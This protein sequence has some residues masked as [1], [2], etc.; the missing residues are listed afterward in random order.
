MEELFN[1]HDVEEVIL[2]E[3]YKLLMRSHGKNNLKDFYKEIDLW[4]LDASTKLDDTEKPFSFI[5]EAQIEESS[6]IVDISL[7]CS[8]RT[9][10]HWGYKKLYPKYFNVV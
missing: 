7:G 2:E 10:G 3:Q 8:S 1:L 5:E 4:F 6:L 9:S